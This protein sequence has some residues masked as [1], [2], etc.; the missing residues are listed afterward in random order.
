MSFYVVFGVAIIVAAYLYWHTR[1]M[2][3]DVPVLT[4]PYEI[5]YLRGGPSEAIRVAVIGLIERGVLTADERQVVRAYDGCE[6]AIADP[7]ER[8]IAEWFDIRGT[9]ETAANSDYLKELLQPIRERLE[10]EGLIVNEELSA[11]RNW[12]IGA[13]LSSLWIVSMTKIAIALG[14]GKHNVLFLIVLTVIATIIAMTALYSGDR[15]AAGDIALRRLRVFHLAKLG[16]NPS[17]NEILLYAAVF[18]AS[19]APLLANPYQRPPGES[20]SSGGCG[21]GDGCGG[22]C[23]GCG[24]D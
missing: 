13:V 3:A 22:G 4:N 1:T 21:G 18:G 24:G 8:K 5:A 12:L 2:R 10:P 23:G 11:V 16:L 20:G 7:F 15:T 9:A 17:G 19:A 14:R 6:P